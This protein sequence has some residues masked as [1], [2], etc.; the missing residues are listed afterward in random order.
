MWI[1]QYSEID[2]LEDVQ[3][4]RA[5]S[6]ERDVGASRYVWLWVKTF[7]LLSNWQMAGLVAIFLTLH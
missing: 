5:A 1:L 2:T 4:L 6:L 3:R 7:P